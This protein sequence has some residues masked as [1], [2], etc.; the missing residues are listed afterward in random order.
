MGRSRIQIE[1]VLLDVLA[2]VAFVAGQAEDAL[3]QN[4][5]S[6]IPE[7]DSETDILVTVADARE[8]L[9]VPAIGAGPGMVMRKSFPSRALG[10]IVLAHSPPGP[11]A[12]IG[13]P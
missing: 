7:R 11:F 6:P 5:V 4:G 3:L 9:F 8:T 12:Q 10:A 1:V 2:V 13:S